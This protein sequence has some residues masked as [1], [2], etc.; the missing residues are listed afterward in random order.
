ME[1][2]T[3][4]FS[5]A[6]YKKDVP[7]YGDEEMDGILLERTCHRL[8]HAISTLDPSREH[9]GTTEVDTFDGPENAFYKVW[10]DGKQR[11]EFWKIISDDEDGWAVVWKGEEYFVVGNYF[12][13][14]F[15]LSSEFAFDNSD[16][17]TED[18]YDHTCITLDTVK[19]ILIDK[20]FEYVNNQIH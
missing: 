15:I 19:R 8:H 13:H 7:T 1:P 4:V 18:D 5:V 3:D 14:P 12:W 16:G 20:P 11:I 2:P 17:S 10:N 9:S 6:R